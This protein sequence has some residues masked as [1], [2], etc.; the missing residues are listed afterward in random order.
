MGIDAV[1]IPIKWCF[2]TGGTDEQGTNKSDVVL[3][4]LGIKI[5]LFPLLFILFL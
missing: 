1:C 3:I 4:D 5:H 2:V